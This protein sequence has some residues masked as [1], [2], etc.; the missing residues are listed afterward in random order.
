MVRLAKSI[1]GSD[2]GIKLDHIITSDGTEAEEM[3]SR[4]DL[5]RHHMRLE[6]HRKHL[7]L[8]IGLEPVQDTSVSPSI[9]RIEPD[10]EGPADE[11]YTDSIDLNVCSKG[12]SPI[13]FRIHLESS[14][15]D[16][17]VRQYQFHAPPQRAADWCVE[18]LSREFSEETFERISR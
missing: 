18:I 12:D 15:E 9:R 13:T 17:I 4:L 3:L 6:V 2:D 5:N 1:E 8:K 14:G 10:S 7:P 11:V 16:E